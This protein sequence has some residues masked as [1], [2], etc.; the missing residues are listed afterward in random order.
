MLHRA[1]GKGDRVVQGVL[2][3]SVVAVVAWL[4]VDFGEG[5]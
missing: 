1:S 4:G 3:M 5:V 2:G